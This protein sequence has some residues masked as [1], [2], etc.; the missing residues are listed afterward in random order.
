[1]SVSLTPVKMPGYRMSVEN[2]VYTRGSGLVLPGESVEGREVLV[3]NRYTNPTENDIVGHFQEKAR[4]IL[5]PK[6]LAVRKIPPTCFETELGRVPLEFLRKI[7]NDDKD[8]TDAIKVNT[9]FFCLGHG[10]KP[11]NYVSAVHFLISDD[12]LL[13][14]DR[15]GYLKASEGVSS[16]NFGRK[17]RFNLQYTDRL[18]ER[19]DIDFMLRNG[20]EGRSFLMYGGFYSVEDVTRVLDSLYAGL[21]DVHEIEKL[22]DDSDNLLDQQAFYTFRRIFRFTPSFNSTCEEDDSSSEKSGVEGAAS[23]TGKKGWVM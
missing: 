19:H 1:M 9:P 4:E 7:A 18:H 14:V 6:A 10:D 2:S 20:V 22:P 3:L 8:F 15:E 23:P 17:W 5:Y 21:K 11:N 16:K 12:E 13:F